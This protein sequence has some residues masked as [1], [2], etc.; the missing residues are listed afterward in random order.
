MPNLSV[1]GFGNLLAAT[2]F[3]LIAATA[4]STAS[5]EPKRGGVLTAVVN[6]DPT[7]LVS[8]HNPVAGALTVSSKMFEGLLAYDID[9]NLKPALAESWEVAPDGLSVTFH[10]RKDVKWHDGQ[11]F[12]SK[13][14]AFTAMKIWKVLHPR[15][16]VTMSKVTEVE[17]PDDHTAIFRLSG[18]APYL[19]SILNGGESQVVP[20]HIYDGADV[21]KNLV[22]KS[23]VGTGPFKL[24]EWRKSQ[25]IV[26]DRNSEYWQAGKPYLDGISFRVIPDE[27]A[28][29]T[30]FETGEVQYGVLN[31][32]SP[33]AAKRLSS[34]PNIEI[35]KR[36]YQFFGTRYML[37]LNL[38]NPI[39]AE[40]RVRQ[41]IAHAIDRQ[42]IL[43]NIWCGNGTLSTGPVPPQLKQFYTADV[44][45]YDF[46]PKKAEELLDAA[47][48]KRGADGMRFKIMH[49]PLPFGPDYMRTAE[50]MKQN[51]K[52]V[53]IDVEIRS[54]D[55]PTW[56]RRIYTDNDF[57]M[58]SNTLSA[59]PDPTLGVQRVYWSK[60]IVKGVPFSNS[61]GYANPEMDKVL[62]AAQSEID[63]EARKKLFYRMQQ[64]AQED[65][66]VID[67][68]VAD[69]NTV[70]AKS[71]KNVTTTADG[72]STLADAYFEK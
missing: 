68:F 70:H 64:I 40:R 26:L 49:D 30:A 29:A 19:L 7:F 28:R 24:K 44:A 33:C 42:F 5:A 27:S 11:P 23:P 15:N 65:L 39:L 4:L 41:A 16:R 1:T 17:T 59:L 69:W 9:M 58:T 45:K 13:D 3:T 60:N 51:L 25:A 32:V 35:D 34:L 50:V 22:E 47:G 72:Y 54:Q 14:V 46:N 56:L 37:E 52:A 71:L 53:G 2:A 62:E 61:S 20:Q 36:G 66:P 6:P 21:A 48:Y 18:P 63:P 38:R 55:T 8:A 43:K 12:T 10:L 31:P 57:D 67:I